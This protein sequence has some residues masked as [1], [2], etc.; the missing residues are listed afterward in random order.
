MGVMELIKVKNASFHYEKTEVFNDLSLKL[1][2]GQVLCLI[3]SNGCGKTTLLDCILVI[4]KLR[5][6]EIL[7]NGVNISKLKASQ[8]AKEICYVPQ[9]HRGT[10]PY[11]VL[12][13]VVM[14]RAVYSGF[15]HM[16]SQKDI[17]IAM[18]ALEMVGMDQYKDKPYTE[19]SG[20]EVQL[21]MIA[22]AMAQNASII[23]MDEPTSHLD[24]RHELIVLENIVKLVKDKGK[25]VIIATHAPNHAFHFE[26]HNIAT[27]VALMRDGGFIDYG[28]PKDV[29]NEV[30]LDK[31]YKV[32]TKIV[33]VEVDNCY[34]MKQILPLK[35]S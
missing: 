2:A 13:I 9:F 16:P 25:A 6:G 7:I 29:V 11:K 22:R 18:E 10:F 27:S 14:G 19:L 15:F 33:D 8:R 17:C 30:N 21:V 31:L 5:K 26:N 23:I 20:G 34:T 12:E 24:M 4:K 35:S 3:G 32:K 28:K 1:N